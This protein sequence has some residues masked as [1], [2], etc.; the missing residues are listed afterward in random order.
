M[1]TI[2]LIMIGLSSFLLAQEASQLTKINSTV[3]D[4]KTGLEW[5]DNSDNN[6]TQKTWQEAID[7]CEALTLDTHDDWRLPNINELKTLIDRTK[8]EPAIKENVFEYIGTNNYYI[9]W[10]SSSFVGH[11]G[12]AWVVHFNYGDVDG[13]SKD[14]NYFVRCVRDGQ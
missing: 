3:T 1:R 14:G 8:R 9:Y 5:Q 2:L 10:S 6:S 12:G 13:Y 4:S 7:Y 11:E